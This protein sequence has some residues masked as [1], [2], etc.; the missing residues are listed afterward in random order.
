MFWLTECPNDD[1]GLVCPLVT[2]TGDVILFCDSGGEAWLDP[3]TVSAE[4]AIYPWTPDW[5]VADGISVAPGTARWADR[6][7][8]PPA[9]STF[10][11]HE[12]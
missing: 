1:Q 3:S 12:T 11:W 7:E 6:A 8:L 10:T 5:R 4:S 9:W 2:A